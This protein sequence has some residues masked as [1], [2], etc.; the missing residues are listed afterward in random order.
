MASSNPR[1]GGLAG[2]VDWKCLA[3]AVTG[4]LMLASCSGRPGDTASSPPDTPASPSATESVSPTRSAAISWHEIVPATHSLNDYSSSNGWF[5]ITEFV[6]QSQVVVRAVRLDSDASW[7]YATESPWLTDDVVPIGDS[8][9]FVEY[10]D[11]AP[12][13][14][15]LI[16]GTPGEPPRVLGEWPDFIPE[17]VDVRGTAYMS[18]LQD[19]GRSAASCLVPVAATGPALFCLPTSIERVERNGTTISFTSWEDDSVASPDG[20]QDACAD[21]YWMDMATDTEPTLM[22]TTGCPSRGSLPTE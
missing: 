3:A 19:P 1:S 11:V 8:V 13:H 12:Y 21:I 10:R 4:V 5:T 20:E 15:R 17:I 7:G 14:A 2:I 9:Y 16:K 18:E 6:P 22:E